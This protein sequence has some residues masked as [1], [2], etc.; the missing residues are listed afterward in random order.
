MKKKIFLSG[1]SGFIGKNILEGLGYKYQFFAPT[2][3]QLDLLNFDI[4][5]KYFNKYG[6]FDTVLHTA[7]IG[8]N[9]KSGDTKDYAID[10]TRMFFNVASNKKLFKR[11]FYFGSGIEYGREKPISKFTESRFGERI[12]Q[13]NWGLYKY[14]CAKHVVDSFN[15]IN[16]RL[17]GVF[18]KYEDWRIRFISNAI[19]K[20]IYNLPITINQN[21]V[22]DYLYIND[23]II[24]LDKFL[25][26]QVKY[27][28][29]NLTPNDKIDLIT[30]AKKVNRTAKKEVKISIKQTGFNKEYT[31]SNK[32]LKNEFTDVKF[33]NID[34]AIY[35]LYKWYVVRKNKIK[36]SDLLQDFF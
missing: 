18:G 17:F 36:R 20:N 11:F 2:H 4:V 3:K 28:D 24:I 8:G 30:L 7:I 21:I 34:D 26:T 29:Y 35:Q 12:P 13:S 14:I 32:R 15:F 6:P 16:L 27:K 19:C 10:S 1:V 25:N 22:M 31:G 9:R 5:K 33:T 23:L